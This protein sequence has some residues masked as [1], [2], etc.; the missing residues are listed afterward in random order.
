M[1]ELYPGLVGVPE[2]FTEET[3]E[4][5]KLRVEESDRRWREI[6]EKIQKAA[7]ALPSIP[8]DFWDGADFWETVD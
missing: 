5:R 3:P 8:T 4:E 6:N 7:E 1:P 2:P